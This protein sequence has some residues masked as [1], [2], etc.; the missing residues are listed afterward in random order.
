MNCKRL[1]LH[2][3]AGTALTDRQ[4]D[5][6]RR[7]T[8]RVAAG[9]P[10][11]YVLGQ[12]EFM[13]RVFRTDR[14]AL[15]PRPETELLVEEVLKCE[16]LW[17]SARPAVTDVGTGTGCVIISLALERTNGLYMAFDT[18]GDAIALARENASALGADKSVA[19]TGDDM[20]DVVEPAML[21]AV[22]SNPPYVATSE[23]ERLP[24]HIRDFEPRQALDGGPD[25]LRVTTSVV[26]DAAI[27]LKPGGRIFLEIGH[28]QAT[29]VRNLLEEAGFSDVSVRR[30][31]AGHDRIVS[32]ILRE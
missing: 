19:F 30:D 17:Q 27:A 4:L 10:V 11:Q 29:R 1:N 7:G 8:K 9:E 22:V 20:S 12:V 23:W 5:A 14:R 32:A 18:S 2:L 21:D 3:H 13:G 26:G 28:D 25:G 15:I 24:R 6:M 16:A 31:T